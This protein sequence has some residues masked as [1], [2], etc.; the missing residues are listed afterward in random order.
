MMMHI[1]MEEVEQ[2]YFIFKV[3]SCN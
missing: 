2:A 3:L 1:A